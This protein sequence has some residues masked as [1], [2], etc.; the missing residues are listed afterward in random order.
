MV[1]KE[2]VRS[3]RSRAP[4]GRGDPAGLAGD[5]DLRIAFAPPPGSATKKSGAPQPWATKAVATAAC[6]ALTRSDR[7]QGDGRTAETTA[8]HPGTQCAGLAGHLDGDVELLA[9]DLVVVAQRGVRGVEQGAER[10]PVVPVQGVDERVHPGHLG[11]D[12]TCAS[13]QRLGKSGEV[14]GLRDVLEPEEAGRLPRLVPARPV[15]AVRELVAD[16]R[17]DD[18]HGEAV[19]GRVERHLAHRPVGE[20]QQQGLPCLRVDRDG[21]VEPSGRCADVLLLGQDAGGGQL[22]VRPAE[23][24]QL[25][26]ATATLHS[27]AAE[28]ESPAPIGT[29]LVISIS[30]PSLTSSARSTPATY[31]AHGSAS[32]SS[33]RGPSQVRS[34]LVIRTTPSARGVRVAVVVWVRAIGR[35]RPPL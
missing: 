8:S 13:E 29:S 18:E 11:D 28:L 9:G 24:Q 19:G 12:V 25:V 16:P 32:S 31:S 33:S 34:A 3:P 6:T 23:V 4:G 26:E 15:A 17:V 21:L 27:S 35:Q 10:G 2:R 14:G 7:D 22:L 20:V 5:H 1:R 30:M